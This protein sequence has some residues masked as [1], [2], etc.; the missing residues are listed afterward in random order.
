[1]GL[2]AEIAVLVFVVS[3]LPRIDLGAAG[4][5]MS[6]A[7]PDGYVSPADT[8]P[9]LP[10]STAW[11]SAAIASAATERA[12]PPR[13]PRET[14]YYE[15][16]AWTLPSFRNLPARQPARPLLPPDPPPLIAV[17]PARPDYVERASDRRAGGA[18][19]ENHSLPV[20]PLPAEALPNR[21]AN[22]FR[23]PDE[24]QY[25][26][27]R[28]TS[29]GHGL[30]DSVGSYF[31]RAAGQLFSSPTSS[32][33]VAPQSYTAPPATGPTAPSGSSSFATAPPPAFAERYPASSPPPQLIFP[34]ASSTVTDLRPSGSF[35][36][37]PA[38]SPR[39][40]Q[41]SQ[42]KRWIKY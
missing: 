40:V 32:P 23:S 19:F 38:Q 39:P 18:S 26:E 14:S 33:A 17:D 28:L 42:L 24:S 22:A 13:L 29:A 11:Q 31:V 36:T 37:E 4:R 1:L 20:T 35:G 27:E 21:E 8:R 16:Q 6:A 5:A 10:P 30:V 7:V 2:V 25:V 3:L 41:P 12:T 9:S 15:D 34:Q